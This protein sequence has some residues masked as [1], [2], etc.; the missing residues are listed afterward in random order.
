MALG[1]GLG[2]LKKKEKGFEGASVVASVEAGAEDILEVFLKEQKCKE[3]KR[4]Q[5]RGERVVVLIGTH[6]VSSL[7]P[8]GSSRFALA[9]GVCHSILSL[10]RSP[11]RHRF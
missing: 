7:F 11:C 3:V 9:V 10:R 5:I 8:P 1:T 2:F 6:Q 4:F